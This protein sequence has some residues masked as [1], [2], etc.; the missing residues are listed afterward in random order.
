VENIKSLM[1]VDTSSSHDEVCLFGG[2]DIGN[3]VPRHRDNI[4]LFAGASTPI[5][6]RSNRLAATLVAAFSARSG[7]NPAATI[8]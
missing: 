6:S 3:R 5:S 7:V 8:A 2:G 1:P 4:G